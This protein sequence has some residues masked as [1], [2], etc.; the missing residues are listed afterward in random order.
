MYD[1]NTYVGIPVRGAAAILTL[2]AIGVI[3]LAHVAN[4][5]LRY[6]YSEYNRRYPQTTDK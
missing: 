6:V 3:A 1:Q 5:G 4:K 2:A